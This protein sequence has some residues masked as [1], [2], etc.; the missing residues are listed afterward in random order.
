MPIARRDHYALTDETRT[1]L[2]RRAEGRCECRMRVCRHHDP[3]ARCG[4]DLN[5]AWQA[6]RKTVKDP[7]VPSNL[8]AMCRL[9]RYRHKSHY[10]E[11]RIMPRGVGAGA[12]AGSSVAREAA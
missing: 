12:W 11:R 2:K 10:A 6:H 1:A 8:I 9:C 7:S 3:G 4:S 5:G